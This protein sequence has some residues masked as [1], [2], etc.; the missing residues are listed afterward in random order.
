M[1]RRLLLPFTLS[2]LAMLVPAGAAEAETSCQRFASPTGSD[3]SAGTLAAPYRS[4]QKLVDSLGAGQTGCLRGG[5]YSGG[6]KVSRG[7]TADAPIRLTAYGSEAARVVGRFWIASGADNVTVD[8]LVLDGT[9][10]PLPSP[11]IYASGATLA[12]N[13]ITNSHNAICV[14]VGQIDYGWH[15]IGTTIV[16][17]RIH[18]CGKLPAAN[19]DHGIYV[20]NATD[21][22]IAGNTISD[23]ADRG[24]NL[25]PNAR[26]TSITG[27]VITGNGQGIL[28]SG[29]FGLATTDTLVEGN[30]IANSTLRYKVEA[31]FTD[32]NYRGD[33]TV[34][35]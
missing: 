14:N 10:S 23:N 3:S 9:G 19:H 27:N 12:D 33:T 29:D 16:R 21:T 25:Y 4:V 28:F 35:P 1:R 17:N 18:G 8:H 15:A 24:I 20:E 7:G 34:R 30:V 32:G 26:R 13:E 11:S 31:W 2:L 5:T 6:V 22:R